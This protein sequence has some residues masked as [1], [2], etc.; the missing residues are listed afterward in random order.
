MTS[1][2]KS[3]YSKEYRK[4]RIH[5]VVIFSKEEFQHL[6]TLA[7]KHRKGFS[8]LV[9]DFALAQSKNQYVLPL[10]EQTH[11]VK[12]LL[13]RYNTNLNQI[14]HIANATKEIS[15]EIIKKVKEE[16]SELQKAIIAIYDKPLR[17]SDLIRN[18]LIKTPSYAEEN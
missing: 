17:L 3:A 4:L 1:D 13:I 11:K 12:I 18:S 16:F 10:K 8:T 6:T 5:R 7:E 9:R 15:L 14:A 2:K